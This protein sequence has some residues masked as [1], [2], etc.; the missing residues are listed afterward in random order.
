MA[1]LLLGEYESDVDRFDAFRQ[2]YCRHIEGRLAQQRA[3]ITMDGGRDGWQ[4]E[5]WR[6]A[7]LLDR[8]TGLRIFNDVTFMRAKKHAKSLDSATIAFY[9][10]GPWDGE[11]G[12]QGIFAAGSEKQAGV[13]G[14]VA[15]N[16]VHPDSPYH[17]PLLSNHFRALR[18]KIHCRENGGLIQVIS[19]RADDVEG[20]G[21]H[22]ASIDEYA[23]HKSPELRDNIQTAMIAREQPLMFTISTVGNDMTRPLYGLER[24]ARD[25][26]IVEQLTPY[27]RVCIDLEAGRLLIKYGLEEGADVDI[28]DPAVLKGVNVASWITVERLIKQLKATD[29]EA[30]FR[31]KHLNQWVDA[32]GEGVPEH[33]WDAAAVAGLTIPNGTPVTVGIDIAYRN[34]WLAVVVA[35][36]VGDEIRF[37]HHLVKPPEADNEEIDVAGTLDDIVINDICR[38]LRVT[39]LRLD[40]ALAVE[41]WQRWTQRGLPVEEFYQYDSKMAPASKRFLSELK[42]GSLR[43]DGDKTY[44]WHVLNA[45]IREL[46]GDRFR[47]DKPRD[48]SQK[49]DGLIATLMALDALLTEPPR[50]RLPSNGLMTL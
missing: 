32:S 36:R 7:L 45:V 43:H 12:P 15:H 50:T 31:R 17:S 49:I 37:E 40:P 41:T 42:R 30:E 33:L 16:M 48:E 3:P 25:W 28:E 35:G 39:K 9:C 47:Y 20:A 19:S 46:S 38:R 24:S 23:V 22:F 13:V 6:L 27:K 44:R 18:G 29:R 10:T 8:A 1:A 26:P 14:R 5:D 21:P 2:H 11:G 34:D 4:Y